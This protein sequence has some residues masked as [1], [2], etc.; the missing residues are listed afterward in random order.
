MIHVRFSVFLNNFFN[1]TQPG[2]K[3]T[4]VLNSQ[5]DYFRYLHETLEKLPKNSF[6][7]TLEQNHLYEG[8]EIYECF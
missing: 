4:D 6:R 3:I 5:L 2:H 1:E 7:S 8:L